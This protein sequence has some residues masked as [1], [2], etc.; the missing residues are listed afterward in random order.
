MTKKSKG[1]KESKEEWATNSLLLHHL[2]IV[3]SP[4]SPLCPVLNT[5]T[6]AFHLVNS[7]SLFLIRNHQGLAFPSSFP[8]SAWTLF[9]SRHLS[10]LKR[11][12]ASVC[13]CQAIFWPTD[14]RH[15]NRSSLLATLIMP[16]AQFPRQNHSRP[17]YCPQ[18]SDINPF[19]PWLLDDDCKM[20][21]SV[22]LYFLSPWTA[23]SPTFILLLNRRTSNVSQKQ[24]PP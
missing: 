23:S 4:S 16:S 12:S 8:A 11:F 20:E 21:M 24:L 19:T 7:V 6:K 15:V 2:L 18:D 14:V 9:P 13:F 22:W 1:T 5:L 10:R 3:T 17:S